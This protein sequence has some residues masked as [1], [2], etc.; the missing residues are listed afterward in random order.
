RV[1]LPGVVH[2]DVDGAEALGRAVRETLDVRGDGH[3][4]DDGEDLP[5]GL[6]G[7]LGARLLEAGVDASADGDAGAGLEQL[8]RRLAPDAA[9]GGGGRGAATMNAEVHAG[10]LRATDA[11]IPATFRAN[12]HGRAP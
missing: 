7:E 10:F 11:I 5:A 9:R 6:R 4:G 2:E 3:V 1:H 12:D 8:P